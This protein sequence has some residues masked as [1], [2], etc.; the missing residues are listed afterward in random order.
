[1]ESLLSCV[2][3]GLPDSYDRSYGDQFFDGYPAVHM[4]EI[5]PR[6][7]FTKLGLTERAMEDTS[8][9]VAK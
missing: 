2:P 8:M 6:L 9:S 3:V 5:R 1:M 4:M 7:G